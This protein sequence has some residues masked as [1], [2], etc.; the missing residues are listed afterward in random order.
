MVEFLDHMAILL[1][2]CLRELHT[3]LHGSSIASFIPI[4]NVEFLVNDLL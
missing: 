1:F 2:V 3:D 4:N